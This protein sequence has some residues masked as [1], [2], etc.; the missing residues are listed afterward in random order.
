MNLRTKEGVYYQTRDYAGILRR[1]FID[2]VDLV[3][4]IILAFVLFIMG[5]WS[6]WL[7]EAFVPLFLVLCYIYLAGLKATRMGTLG[8]ILAG[9]R[10]VN[11]QG[12]QASIWR[13]SFRL[14]LILLGPLNLLFDLLWVGNDPNRQSIRDKF[15]G[16]YVVRRKANPTGRGP[17]SYKTYFV[18]SYTLLFPEIIRK[19]TYKS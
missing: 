17:I 7:S 14:G 18:M 10:L 2:T 15:A 13:S 8:Y 5:A 1:L 12:Q 19:S 4:L 6:D 16:T 9:V 3:V 11:L